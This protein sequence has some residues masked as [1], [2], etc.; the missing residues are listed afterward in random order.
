MSGREDDFAKT[1]VPI[2]QDDCSSGPIAAQLRFSPKKKNF[3][4]RFINGEASIDYVGGE[5]RLNCAYLCQSL[6]RLAIAQKSGKIE[7]TTLKLY[8]IFLLLLLA[9]IL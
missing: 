9:K 4:N 5:V 2:K 3:E 7:Q 1:S 8:R 6:V